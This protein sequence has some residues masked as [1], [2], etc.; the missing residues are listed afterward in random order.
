[1][2][3]VRD[4]AQVTEPLNPVTGPVVVDGAEP[5]DVLA[6]TIHVIELGDNGWSVYIPG[7][8]AL[9]G[10]PPPPVIGDSHSRGSAGHPL[11]PDP[12]TDDPRRT[13]RTL[14]NRSAD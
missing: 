6:V 9:A 7:A 1:M 11:A 14:V 8:G 2:D 3:Q 13:T 4:L 5:G 10:P 12:R